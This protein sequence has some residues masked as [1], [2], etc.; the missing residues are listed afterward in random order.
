MNFI[1]EL[2]AAETYVDIVHLTVHC[3]MPITD[4]VHYSCMIYVIYLLKKFEYRITI[5]QSRRLTLYVE[6]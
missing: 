3:S 1:R 5:I 2:F 4:I 6:L